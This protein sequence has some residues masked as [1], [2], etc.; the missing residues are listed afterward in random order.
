MIYNYN[1]WQI[2]TCYDVMTSAGPHSLGRLVQK[3]QIE[4]GIALDFIKESGEEYLYIVDKTETYVIHREPGEA[5]DT[6][7]TVQ[8][9]RSVDQA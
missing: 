3:Y 4:N 8:P 7:N 2:G 9:S 1:D 6:S 5:L